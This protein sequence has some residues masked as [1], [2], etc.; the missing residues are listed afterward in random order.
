MILYQIAGDSLSDREKALVEKYVEELA[1]QD[2]EHA[3][4]YRQNIEQMNHY[5][6]EYTE[7][8]A[9][10]FDPDVEKA[11]DSSAAL[12]KSVGGGRRGSDTG[13]L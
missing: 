6:A 7:L 12:A 2:D 1:D 13:Q 5:I 8:L 10:A 11:F 9:A 4:R 3:R